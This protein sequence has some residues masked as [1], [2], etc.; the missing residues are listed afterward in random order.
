ML[1]P[2]TPTK[3]SSCRGGN[4]D[5]SIKITFVQAGEGGEAKGDAVTNTEMK[6]IKTRA[7]VRSRDYKTFVT[8]LV[9]GIKQD[10]QFSSM[11]HL[12]LIVSA[13]KVRTAVDSSSF[14]WAH[15][16][17]DSYSAATILEIAGDSPVI[18]MKA[19]AEAITKA[20]ATSTHP[21]R[22]ASPAS[23]SRTPARSSAN[24]NGAGAK[25]I[26]TPSRG[27]QNALFSPPHSA[28]SKA[29]RAKP[30]FSP[31]PKI[32]R[33][34]RLPGTSTAALTSNTTA[35]SDAPDL[36]AELD[37]ENGLAQVAAKPLILP[38][39]PRSVSDKDGAAENEDSAARI[40]AGAASELAP[41]PPSPV[42]S[43]KEH[44]TR[45]LPAHAAAKG[46]TQI[47]G[48]SPGPA[49]S[50]G[51]KSAPRARTPQRTRTAA[52]SPSTHARPRTPGKPRTPLAEPK[53]TVPHKKTE[54]S[55]EAWCFEQTMR[56]N[57]V[58][59]KEGGD[60]GTMQR[61]G[62]APELST[63]TSAQESGTGT[64]RR[65]TAPSGGGSSE[66]ERLSIGTA[67]DQLEILKAV[68]GMTDEEI[69]WL[70]DSKAGNAF[71]IA[72][73]KKE[74]AESAYD[75][76]LY[77]AGTLSQHL[78]QLDDRHVD[79]AL[80]KLAQLEYAPGDGSDVKEAGGLASGE[81]DAQATISA[82]SSK[83]ASAFQRSGGGGEG[84]G[85]NGV[86][87]EAVK[88]VLRQA[89][90]NHTK[91]PKAARLARE[92]IITEIRVTKEA[93]AKNQQDVDRILSRIELWQSRMD[94]APQK[95]AELD[96][97][98][99]EWYAANDS[100]NRAALQIMRSF[101]PINIAS[102]SIP[103]LR[104]LVSQR[105]GLF[106][107]ELLHYLK[108]CKLL[109]WLIT[110]ESEIMRANFLNG[111]HARH[112]VSLD[113]YDLIEMRALAFV[114]QDIKFENDRDGKKA[115]WLESFNQRVREL[116]AREDG[117]TVKGGWDPVTKA[118]RVN[119]L[120]ALE[121]HQKRA[122]RYFY[123]SAAEVAARLN[124]YAERREKLATREAKVAVIRGEVE[125]L[126]KE[127][128]AALEDSRSDELKRLYGRE[129]LA[130][131]RQACKTELEAKKREL[132]T[133]E[134][135]VTSSKRAIADNVP[136]EP[137][138]RQEQEQVALLLSERDTN[139]E[140]G[141]A[142]SRP[143]AGIF[144]EEPEIAAAAV[145]EVAKKL[146]AEEE[147][148]QRKMDLMMAMSARKDS[149]DAATAAAAAASEEDHS[150]P[151][152]KQ[153]VERDFG[154]RRPVAVSDAVR[155]CLIAQ[156][157][158][159]ANKAADHVNQSAHGRR[160]EDLGANGSG[161]APAS[162]VVRPASKRLQKLVAKRAVPTED[163]SAAACAQIPQVKPSFLAE[164]QAKANRGAV[165][166]PRSNRSAPVGGD[167]RSLMRELTERLGAR[168]T[169]H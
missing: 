53:F 40:V 5:V 100:K 24:H 153:D 77:I 115:A 63:P 1:R 118:R 138:F 120:P 64:R 9:N 123:P 73:K 29:G 78:R 156:F 148:R 75:R 151:A 150:C 149:T 41:P 103:E 66:G 62:T 107:Q 93:A 56:S 4:R 90:R 12:E 152:T 110:H 19:T 11:R 32:L 122:P 114:L 124:K 161:A 58:L 50:I 82:L 89:D 26:S 84:E 127:Y 54:A 76:A 155:K 67:M 117:G 101:L 92:R 121:P 55:T 113:S 160:E 45:S 91:V 15:V 94:S 39:Q 129:Q 157:S 46:N 133:A 8:G 147:A 60:V 20:G 131:N 168:N 17:E 34:R 140:G 69:Q 111:S 36:K 154:V 37:K 14:K 57:K 48:K 21:P 49:T 145:S 22:V 85:G 166:A 68:T 87:S 112:F 136:D 23:G 135:A 25:T 162:G 38:S 165:E 146:S 163:P 80:A 7:N 159:S 71:L 27:E 144:D 109:H 74:A 61:R 116:V 99:R 132:K 128:M 134:A 79:A 6:A 13:I 164:L 105:G 42:G 106:P 59:A 43:M 81:E 104:K 126:Q 97:R 52:P 125:E 83:L 102:L 119:M 72:E 70:M 28:K 31:K 18:V 167:S 2:S 142:S 33:E 35:V 86:L 3:L 30:V 51:L 16:N 88:Q 139:A 169:A 137:T 130:L 65:G 108:E 95:Q 47:G 10:P 141:D 44:H 96:R 158:S 98:Q 143:V